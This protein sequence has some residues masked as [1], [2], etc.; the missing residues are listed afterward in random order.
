MD[1]LNTVV[2]ESI[3]DQDN[4]SVSELSQNI[5]T[6][7]NEALALA[8]LD[9]NVDTNGT[10]DAEESNET[11]LQSQSASLILQWEEEAKSRAVKQIAGMLRRPEQ[12]EKVC[13]KL[14]AQNYQ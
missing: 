3:K 4:S 9:E 14:V 12:L 7:D 10:K 13:L 1:K 2:S 6:C 11:P 8:V 5:S